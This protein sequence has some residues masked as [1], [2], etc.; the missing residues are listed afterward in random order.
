VPTGGIAMAGDVTE[1][2]RHLLRYLEDPT[3]DSDGRR[4]IVDH[5][6]GDLHGK[7]GETLAQFLEARLSHLR[8]APPSN[9]SIVVEES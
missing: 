2:A 4:K 9:N 8:V 7:A 6:C 1:V 5:V 3:R